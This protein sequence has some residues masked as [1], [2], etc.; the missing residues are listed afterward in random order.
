[1][2]SQVATKNITHLNDSRFVLRHEVTLQLQHSRVAV[3]G[4]EFV[5]QNDVISGVTSRAD[6]RDVLT[7][8]VR[9]RVQ[10]VSL[11]NHGY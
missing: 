3:H 6:S 4:Y 1:M 10:A 7:C 5:I 8:L 2:T 11:H 9:D